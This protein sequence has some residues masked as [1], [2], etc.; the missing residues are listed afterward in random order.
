MNKLSKY[1]GS[2]IRFY[3][4]GFKQTI[5]TYTFLGFAKQIHCFVSIFRGI[6]WVAVEH[7]KM[8]IQGLSLQMSEY[9]YKRH[10]IYHEYIWYDM[11][12]CTAKENIQ[13]E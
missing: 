3:S 13:N 12:Q 8:K 9:I 5:D 6:E 10:V 11:L 4:F 2:K 7:H 1:S